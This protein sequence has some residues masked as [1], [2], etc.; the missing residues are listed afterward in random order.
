MAIF[1]SFEYS[2]EKHVIEHGDELDTQTKILL[3]N[4]IELLDRVQKEWHKRGTDIDMTCR[5]QLRQDCRETYNAICAVD[6]RMCN[7]KKVKKLYNMYQRLA[8][9]AEAVLKMVVEPVP[10]LE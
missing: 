5:M 2:E 9:E 1:R 3:I 8:A 6:S 7:E 10:E 4:T